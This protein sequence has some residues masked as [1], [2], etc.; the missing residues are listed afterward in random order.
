MHEQL[1]SAENQSTKTCTTSITADNQSYKTRSLRY[2]TRHLFNAPRPIFQNTPY[3][4]YFPDPPY[5]TL[6]ISS[7]TRPT[8]QNT[9]YIQYSPDP[10]YKIL[11]ISSTPRPTLQN[12]PYLQYSTTHLTKHSIS[13]VLHHLPYKTL[14]ISSTPPPTLQNTPYLQYSTTYLT[15]HTISQVLLGWLHETSL[16][17]STININKIIIINFYWSLLDRNYSHC[18]HVACDSEKE[19]KY[20]A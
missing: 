18:T 13:P 3:V 11:H 10:P 7:T 4:Q 12:T 15:K 2:K 9:P 17:C 20:G 14:H 16:Q 5:K 19:S 8:L 6:H 1:K